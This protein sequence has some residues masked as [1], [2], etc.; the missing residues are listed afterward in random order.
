MSESC[1][2]S[3]LTCGLAC[4]YR[5]SY[6]SSLDK[7]G[8]PSFSVELLTGRS[9]S[10]SG[11]A[12]FYYS[13]RAKRTSTLCDIYAL[14]SEKKEV[15]DQPPENRYSDSSID[16]FCRKKKS[17]NN[18]LKIATTRTAEGVE[19]AIV[20]AARHTGPEPGQCR[21]ACVSSINLLKIGT[22]TAGCCS[23]TDRSPFFFG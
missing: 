19:A 22:R 21:W 7:I 20:S 6:S 16:S 4:G 17:S 5:Y 11:I 8:L 3:R 14:Y 15:V 12:G 1:C 9:A 18:L 10:I 2:C 13:V 23:I